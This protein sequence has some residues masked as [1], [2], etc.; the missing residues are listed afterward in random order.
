MHRSLLRIIR[1]IIWVKSKI[2]SKFFTNIRLKLK[3]WMNC[4]KPL[5]KRKK[6]SSSSFCG[7]IPS[8]E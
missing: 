8:I 2:K 7:Q 5:S 1:L 4:C 3:I 6:K